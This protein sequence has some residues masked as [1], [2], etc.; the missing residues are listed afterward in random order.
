VEAS[1]FVSLKLVVKVLLVVL[2]HSV[3]VVESLQLFLPGVNPIVLSRHYQLFNY[4]II[5]YLCRYF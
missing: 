4:F 1:E 2:D 5:Y 3:A